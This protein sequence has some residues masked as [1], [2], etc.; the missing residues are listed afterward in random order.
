[1]LLV[2][3]GLFSMISRL[4]VLVVFSGLMLVCRVWSF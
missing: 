2:L 4:V 3:M 1:M